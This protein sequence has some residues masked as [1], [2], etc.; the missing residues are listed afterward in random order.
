MI[1]WQLQTS[2]GPLDFGVEDLFRDYAAIVEKWVTR[3]AGPA[4]D[5]DDVVQEVFMVVQRRLAEWRAEAKISTWL[6]RITERVVHRQ[7]HKQRLGQW[8]AGLAEDFTDQIPC[9]APTPVAQLESKQTLTIVQRALDSLDPRQ[10]EA[11]ALFELEGLSGHEIAARTGTKYATVWVR[12][13]R[14]RAQF[15][16]RLSELRALEETPEHADDADGSL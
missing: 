15:R 16:K 2:A 14:G 9:Q 4:V 13:H 12:L 8:A 3:L 1:H 5:A 11:V 7:R 10:R 6:Y